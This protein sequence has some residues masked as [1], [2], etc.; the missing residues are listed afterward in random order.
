MTA[1][2]VRQYYNR[3]LFS[4]GVRKERK[5]RHEFSVHGFRKFFKTKAELGGMR[6]INVET[7]MGHSTGISDSYYRPTDN[8]LLEDYLKAVDNLTITYDENRLQKQVNELNEKSKEENY[9]IKGKLSEKEKEIELFKQRFDMLQEQQNQKDNDF[10]EL[11]TAVQFL[12]D[13]VNS[14]IITSNPTTKVIENEKGIPKAIQ[15]THTVGTVKA[16][17]AK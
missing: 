2:A 4:I 11:K 14:A 16:E 12:K 5:R 6:P 17:I 15:F 1:P 3:L 9:I 8:D 13:T 7:L 10:N